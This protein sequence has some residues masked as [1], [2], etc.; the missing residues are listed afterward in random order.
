MR[1]NK[2]NILILKKNLFNKK[3]FNYKNLINLVN[4]YCIVRVL[5]PT[6]Y[7]VIKFAHLGLS[8]YFNDFMIFI[9]GQNSHLM[10]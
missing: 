3:L 8:M 6:N 1:K 7:N 4:N 5:N 2:I 10:F 9:L